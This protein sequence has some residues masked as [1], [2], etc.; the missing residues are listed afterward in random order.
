MK[1]LV[2]KE[3]IVLSFYFYDGNTSDYDSIVLGRCKQ[4]DRGQPGSAEQT[5]Q[6]WRWRKKISCFVARETKC[7]DGTR[8]FGATPGSQGLLGY[9]TPSLT[10]WL[11]LK[12]EESLGLAIAA[13]S[14]S[15]WWCSE[16]GH[17]VLLVPVGQSLVLCSCR[18]TVQ[19]RAGH[20]AHLCLQK[21][22]VPA[23]YYLSWFP[24]RQD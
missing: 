2:F 10:L 14:G 16:P 20:V 7:I 9:K 1:S 11:H 22:R 8:H 18:R 13:G 24:W 19:R 3:D 15:P 23:I 21:A 5:R 6:Q 12:T 17:R 4:A